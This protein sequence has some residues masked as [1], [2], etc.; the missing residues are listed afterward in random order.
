MPGRNGVTDVSNAYR[1]GFQRQE[2]DNEIKGRGNSLNYKYRMHD[3]RIGRFFSVDPL[4]KKYPWNSSYAFSENRVIDGVE[5]EGL[6]VEE[7]NEFAENNRRAY[8]N[9]RNGGFAEFL[10][11]ERLRLT[12]QRRIE[13]LEFKINIQTIIS[14]HNLDS[15]QGEPIGGNGKSGKLLYNILKLFDEVQGIQKVSTSDVVGFT[16]TGTAV[17]NDHVVRY[18]FDNNMPVGFEANLLLSQWEME[19]NNRKDKYIQE[20]YN[21]DNPF[22]ASVIFDMINYPSPQDIM[23]EIYENLEKSDIKLIKKIEYEVIPNISPAD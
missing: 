13:L 4:A 3:P 14:E 6:E 2:M 18:E 1:Y 9:N 23:R 10:K 8:T 11:R 16:D 21:P 12:E 20:H 15:P 5:L 17:T 7:I 19:Y 22:E